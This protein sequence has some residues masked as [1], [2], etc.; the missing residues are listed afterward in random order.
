M[1]LDHSK[2]FSVE[3]QAN[4]FNL[5]LVTLQREGKPYA[6]YTQL[7][8]ANHVIENSV[9]LRG[10][11]LGMKVARVTETA[12]HQSRQAGGVGQGERGR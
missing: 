2:A 6:N 10:D 9:I 4:R 11:R 7:C 3:L 8:H 1:F 5:A 12:I